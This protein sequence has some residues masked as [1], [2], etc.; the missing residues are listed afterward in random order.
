M[1]EREIRS[2]RLNDLPKQISSFV[3]KNLETF[4]SKTIGLE[5][6]YSIDDGISALRTHE[7]SALGQGR[8]MYNTELRHARLAVN[9]AHSLALIILET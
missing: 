5:D 3:D 4:P 6:I 7:S 8:Q 2:Q 1:G 9:S